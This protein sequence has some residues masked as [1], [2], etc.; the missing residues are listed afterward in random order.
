M[1]KF[2]D[3]VR[4]L[5]TSAIIL[6]GAFTTVGQL[7]PGQYIAVF[8][9]DVPDPATAARDLADQAGLSV[10]HVYRHSIQG[11]A[12]AGSEQGAQALARNP[13]IAYVEQDQ[14][15]HASAISIP[16]GV[17]RVGL[18]E[19][20]LADI[21]SD[22]QISAEG[23]VAAN[24]AIVD[25][26]IQRDHPDLNVDQTGVRFYTRTVKGK[27]Q[28]VFD[29][30]FDD[31]NG[32]GTHVSGTAAADGAIMG[33]APGALLTAVKVLGASGS[34][35]FSIVIAGVDWVAGQPARFDVANMSLGG[36]FSQAVNDAVK[37]ATLKGIVFVVAAGNAA[38]DVSQM[39]PASEPTAITVS[40][41][42]DFDGQP[43]GLDTTDTYTS[44]KN[45]DGTGGTIHH[46]EE[47]P[48]W[49]NFGAGVD[50]CAPGVLIY[51]TWPTSLI[52]SG[53]NTISG[54]SMAAPHVTGAAALYIAKNRAS[55]ARAA[56]WA[57][58][59]TAALKSSGW[60]VGDYGYFNYYTREPSTVST[61]GDKD[62][63]REPLL[64][65]SS[66]LGYTSRP[67]P[68]FLVTILSPTDDA[69][70]FPSGTPVPLTGTAFLGSDDVTDSLV[71]TSNVDGPL[72]IGGSVP[73][74]L[75]DGTH[76]IVASVPDSHSTFGGFASIT[77][78]SGAE[79]PAPKQLF[80]TLAFDKDGDVPVYYDGETM[81]SIFTVKDERGALVQDASVSAVM[82]TPAGGTLTASGLTD[83]NGQFDATM[84]M[85]GKRG[86][87]YGNYTITGSAT[88]SGYLRSAEV[89]RKFQLSK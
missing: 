35:A 87:G 62:S 4:L 67:A 36:G 10:S 68:D 16:T 56:D 66:L 6:G 76:I 8:K 88:K 41:M 30:T 18:D 81:H 83:A 29:N 59:V 49:S 33:V 78:V 45:S 77:I 17:S 43:G 7:I 1:P 71:W 65:V 75:S 80:I 42:A 40:A 25:T 3:L 50:I 24:I 21:K 27:T 44:C 13:R 28:I 54:T 19:A 38:T 11:F 57:A 20:K 5:L 46:D 48:C 79:T 84:R 63:F 52:S 89:T 72:G 15:A 47:V 51:S 31:D 39:S 34:G 85:N 26:G 74:S 9:P 14:L 22:S 69:M 2:T 53:Y 73:A 64:D 55:R 37:N 86:G 61:T 60:R 23:R 12:F 82:K 32:H 70:V 58:D